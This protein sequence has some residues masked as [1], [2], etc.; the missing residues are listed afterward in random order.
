M[1]VSDL[2]PEVQKLST[3]SVFDEWPD[4]QKLG[5]GQHHIPALIEI[6]RNAPDFWRDEA[7]DENFFMPLHAWKALVQLRAPEAVTE[8]LYAM[9]WLIDENSDSLLF[10]EFPFVFG[11]LDS[12]SVGPLI[13]YLLNQKNDNEARACVAEGL[14][15]L[16]ENHPEL[17]EEAIQ[18]FRTTL[19]RYEEEDPFFNAVFVSFLAELDAVEAAPLVEQVY[20]SNHVDTSVIGDWEDFQVKVGL[21]E[22]RRSPRAQNMQ[23]SDVFSIDLTREGLPITTPYP[24]FDETPQEQQ[25]WKELN[26][27]RNKKEKN[28]LKEAKSARKKH[29]KKK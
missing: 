17:R 21:L 19:E 7:P 5:I 25:K 9:R 26:K 8:L 28:K 12:S 29:H 24:N 27:K 18:A 22:K 15:Y 16:V 6:S 10:E 4:Y 14:V 20:Q 23:F 3:L 1:N 13:E 11:R 2:P